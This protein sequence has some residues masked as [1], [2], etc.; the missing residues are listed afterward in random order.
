MATDRQ[1]QDML[2][3][4]LPN[5]MLKEELIQRDYVLQQVQRDD[6]W[7][8]GN[9]VVPFK[10]ASASSVRFGGLTAANTIASSKYVRGNISDY[11]EVWGSLI[12]D[13]RDLQEHNGKLNEDSFLRL[14]PDEVEDFMDYV[15]QVTSVQL[16]SGPHFATVDVDGTSLGVLGV[17]HID[18]F[19]IDQ[20]VLLDD[21][22]SAAGTYFVTAINVN[23]EK[24]TV[25]ATRGGAVADVSGYTVAQ[26]AKL[27]HPGVFDAGGAHDTFVSM[28]DA[29]LS[30]ANGGST[31]LHG[32]T[33]TAYPILQ[34]VNI[35]GTGITATNILERLF[36]ALVEQRRR[37]K[38][39]ATE[40]LMDLTNMGSVLMQL[41]L[42][43]GSYRVVEE[44]KENLFGWLE[45]KIAS[46][47]GQ[48]IKLVGIQEME[49]DLIFLIDWRSIT[50]RT[51]GFFKKRISPDGREYFEVRNTT[52]FQYIVDTCLF[53][54]MEYKKPGHSAVIHT[55]AY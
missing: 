10:G 25:S 38:G 39:M 28:R 4:Y 9:L 53:G 47:T 19:E 35:D 41:E 51:N 26:S 2:N 21:G 14:L 43:K 45:M 1:F 46:V 37:G 55:V 5:E 12:F 20:E 29:F 24:I 40:F 7:K 34:A 15:K 6:S 18:R 32:K 49:T 50:F 42:Q 3:E 13:Q 30:A 44:P 54:E 27:Y 17:D 48:V 23:D 31:T 52:G 8:G 11:R 36:L 16:T 33:K 22:N